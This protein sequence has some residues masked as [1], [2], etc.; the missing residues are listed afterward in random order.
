MNFVI[1]RNFIEIFRRNTDV[2]KFV[3]EYSTNSIIVHFTVYTY[4]FQSDAPKI[5][6][7]VS[8]YDLSFIIDLGAGRQFNR[9][10]VNLVLKIDTGFT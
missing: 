3:I 7:C 2:P 1:G 8:Q 6:K 10:S 9:I 5:N 4:F